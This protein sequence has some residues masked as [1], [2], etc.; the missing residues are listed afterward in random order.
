MQYEENI[1]GRFHPEHLADLRKS[2]LSDE[3]ITQH[4]IYSACPSEIKRILGWDSPSIQSALVFP[5]PGSDFVRVKVFPLYKDQNGHTVK[6]LQRKDSGVHLYI[7]HQVREILENT[8]ISLVLTEGEK[9]ALAACQNGFHALGLGGCWN[10]LLDGKPIKDLDLFSWKGRQVYIVFDSDALEKIE[11][12]RAEHMLAG[13][14][15]DRGAV[16]GIVRLPQRGVEKVGLDDYLVTH[17]PEALKKLIENARG[18][19]GSPEFIY[20][21][22]LLKSGARQE[23]V[24]EALA[25]IL[26]WVERENL[27]FLIKEEQGINKS[28]LRS[29]IERIQRKSYQES[30]TESKGVND[31]IAIFSGLV[32]IVEADGQ[33]AFLVKEDNE[34]KVIHQYCYNGETFAPPP[35]AGMPWLLPRADMVLRAFRED[36]NKALYDDL[37]AYHRSISE[38]P[39]DRY[40]DLLTIWDFHTYLL[41]KFQYSS[42]L[43]LF[44]VPER[45]K[46][47]TGKGLI[48]VA[49]RGIHVESLRDAYLVRVANNYCATLFI[50]TLDLWRKAERNGTEDLLLQRYEKGA[51]VPRVLYPERGPHKDT[52]YFKVFGATA[53]AT[54][55]P[56]SQILESRALQ[57]TM[58]DSSKHFND[59]VTPE[60][61]LSLKERL[62]AFR[63]RYLDKE[64]PPANK[65][66]S[67]RLGDITRPLVQVIRLVTPEREPVL[68][69]LIKE[70]D[71]Q[72]RIDKSETLEAKI[73]TAI[74][75]NLNDVNQGMLPFDLIIGNVNAE[76][77]EKW[78]IGD[79]T[80][81]R[82]LAALGMKTKKIMGKRF[83]P[84]PSNIDHIFCRYGVGKNGTN[85]TNGSNPYPERDSLVPF[86]EAEI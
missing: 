3:T 19:E 43:Y 5:Y 23:K 9:K 2:G 50:D 47:R 67:G 61:A 15:E 85:G 37:I 42:Y 48:Y 38:L 12:L 30:A 26:S 10:F 58:G 8:S 34:L 68:I 11:V 70:V 27:I 21:K 81:G 71:E 17:G 76:L 53:I 18:I 80:F 86:F 62:V 36:N 28:A 29:E 54:N 16:G 25:R 64:L 55:E 4:G 20:A 73:L 13:L 57:L 60:S 46:S 45:G 82:K 56:V 74:S 14:L 49:Y 66:T 24:M 79:K 32:D 72:K 83:I 51:R 77:P 39:D 31:F 41:E 84:I 7:P 6:Y 59:D 69:D 40:Y 75:N 63:A 65:P 22:G 1:N 78:R 52:V 35:R 33:P 44:A